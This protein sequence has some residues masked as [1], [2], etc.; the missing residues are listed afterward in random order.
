MPGGAVSKQAHPNAVSIA[1][2]ENDLN[3]ITKELCYLEPVR[4][5]DREER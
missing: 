4:A 3:G 2:Q 1:V 5:W